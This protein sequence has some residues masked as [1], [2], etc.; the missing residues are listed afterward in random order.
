M[1][2]IEKA[3]NKQDKNVTSDEPT[4]HA[5]PVKTYLP[6]TDIVDTEEG[7][8]IWAE[9]PGVGKESINIVLDK[10]VLTIEG[11]VTEPLSPKGY[12]LRVREYPVGHYHRTFKLGNEINSDD[13]QARMKNGVLCLTLPRNKA[14][15]PKKINVQVE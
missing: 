6:R 5:V 7:I 1:S 3:E 4:A 13:I 11:H 2:V 8:K 14:M 15:G 12:S 9:M 10:H